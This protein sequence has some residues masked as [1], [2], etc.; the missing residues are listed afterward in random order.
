[1]SWYRAAGHVIL[2]LSAI[3]TIAYFVIAVGTGW[4]DVMPPFLA[5]LLGILMGV[6]ALGAGEFPVYRWT[7]MVL[8]DP[9][10]NTAQRVIAGFCAVVAAISA[11]IASVIAVTYFLPL[12]MPAG[13]LDIQQ[14]INLANL[15]IGW[16]V[17]LVGGVAYS[18][19]SSRS[20]INATMA[21]ATNSVEEAK[22]NATRQLAQRITEGSDDAIEAMDVAPEVMRLIASQLGIGAGTVKRRMPTDP[23]TPQAQPEQPT[24][25][26]THTDPNTG[27]QREW[28]TTLTAAEAYEVLRNAEANDARPTNGRPS[29]NGSH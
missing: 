8:A 7:G 29:Q 23:P 26:Y 22:A 28:E 12:S 6:L 25:T 18:V 15:G 24:T 17:V 21:R 16:A 10:I 13:W 1:M 14:W 11:A 19:A 5:Y 4:A 3:T 27:E 9:E 2:T 20:S